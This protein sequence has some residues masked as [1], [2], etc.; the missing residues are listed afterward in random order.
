MVALVLY[1]SQMQKEISEPEGIPEFE[2]FTLPPT[3]QR[4]GLD[5]ATLMALLATLSNDGV[6]G[7]TAILGRLEV[8]TGA[9]TISSASPPRR[10][11]TAPCATGRARQRSRV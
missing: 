10:S 6:A 9:E 1:S 11:T 4:P 7:K 2:N 8:A 3:A 5:A